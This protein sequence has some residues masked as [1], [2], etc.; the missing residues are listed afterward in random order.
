MRNNS[1]IQSIDKQAI[2]ACTDAHG[3]INYVNDNFCKISG[4]SKKELLGQ[5]HQ[6]VNSGFHKKAFF[7]ELWGTIGSGKAWIGEICNRSKTGEIYWVNTT[8]SP[9]IDNNGEILGFFSIR[10]DITK[11]K[12]L[13]EENK[14]LMSVNRAVQEIAKVG[15]WE[16]D[17]EEEKVIWTDQT[18]AIHEVP[19]GV[20]ITKEMGISFYIEEDRPRI[21]KNIKECIEFGKPWNDFFQIV[22]AKGRKLW[23]RAAGE[24][25]YGSDG[26]VVKL[27]GTFQDV[28]EMKEAEIKADQ[29]RKMFLH[30]AKLSTLG[31]MASSMIHEISNPLTVI[32]GAISS[33]KRRDNL[34]DVLKILNKAEAP[35]ERLL[36]MVQNL[37]K[38]S[39]NETVNREVKFNNVLD[40]IKTSEE[41]TRYKF[42]RSHVDFRIKNSNPLMVNCE[43]SEMEQVFVNIFNNAVDAVED[44]EDRWVEVDHY[45][46]ATKGSY[47]TITDSGQGIPT[48]IADNIFNSFYTTKEKGKGTGIGLGVVSDIITE[49]GATIIVD[50]SKKHTC[51]VIHFPPQA[52]EQ[53][54]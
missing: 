3:I 22:T 11:Q 12:L 40:I 54:G 39:R 15:G 20:Q 52:L 18:F 10:Y 50:H 51:F 32:S 42:R 9:D 13:E 49:H 14:N 34:E 38:Y 8:I 28:N 21:A 2:I 27:R 30:S 7:K 33:A 47:I 25:T 19:I 26:K 17:L 37:R 23:V 36:K 16:L 1:F 45:T 29:E 41:Y 24:G 48:E 35:L 53:I 43:A 44:L 6:I 4:Y 5:T 31:E 46:T